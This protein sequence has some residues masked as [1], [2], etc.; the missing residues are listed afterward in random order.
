M[1]PLGFP[2]QI[3][4]ILFLVALPF[5]IIGIILNLT[6]AMKSDDPGDGQVFGAVAVAGVFTY[7]FIRQVDPLG[8]L[9]GGIV[10]FLLWWLTSREGK[11]PASSDP[12]PTTASPTA[13]HPNP[14]AQKP[15]PRPSSVSPLS[16]VKK[17]DPPPPLQPLIPLSEVEITEAMRQPIPPPPWIDPDDPESWNEPFEEPYGWVSASFQLDDERQKLKSLFPD[18][19]EHTFHVYCELFAVI[20]SILD[21][22]PAIG[23]ETGTKGSQWQDEDYGVVEQRVLADWRAK[24]PELV[25]RHN[26]ST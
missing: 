19:D 10:A 1:T 20:D 21:E 15:P 22:H 3:L 24:H 26:L 14:P 16:M 6:G 18:W 8:Y 2:L 11:G 13:E 7:W 4:A 12:M 9:I 17:V 5:F 23:C 25:R